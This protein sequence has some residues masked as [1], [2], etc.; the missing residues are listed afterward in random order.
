MALNGP[1]WYKIKLENFNAPIRSWTTITGNALLWLN[2]FG[3]GA[4]IEEVSG[5]SSLELG[6]THVFEP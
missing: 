1:S 4:G 3:F 2:R 6:G 5:L